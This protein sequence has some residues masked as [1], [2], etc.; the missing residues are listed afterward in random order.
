MARPKKNKVQ[1]SDTDVK[2]IKDILKNKDTSQT[3][4]N[5]CRILLAL[6][7]NHPP[8]QT[9]DQCMDLFCVS[10]ATI[11]NVAKTFVRDRTNGFLIM[12]YLKNYLYTAN[13]YD[14]PE[15]TPHALM[16]TTLSGRRISDCILEP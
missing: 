4:V 6:D 1:L 15:N 2:K 8:V 10:R 7:E 5:R 12:K 14:T 9:Y 16:D 11:S 3:I 13:D